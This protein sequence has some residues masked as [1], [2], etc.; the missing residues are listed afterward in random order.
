[1]RDIVPS[2]TLPYRGRKDSDNLAPESWEKNSPRG[3]GDTPEAD[4]KI[5]ITRPRFLV[6]SNNKAATYVEIIWK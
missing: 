4:S 5:G 6:L 2:L 1:M 3:E